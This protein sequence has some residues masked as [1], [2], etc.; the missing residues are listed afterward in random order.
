MIE[1][2]RPDLRLIQVDIFG[3][4]PLICNKWSDKAKRE[5][6][7]KQMGKPKGRDAACSTDTK[8]G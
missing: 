4:T 7:D 2:K 5:M 1:I 6:L 8:S 3:K